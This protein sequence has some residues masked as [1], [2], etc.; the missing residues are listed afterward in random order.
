MTI[1]SARQYRQLAT[2]Y[3][4]FGF[5]L[6]PLGADK[7]P[8]VTGVAPNGRI[9]HFFWEDWK[10]T[11]QTDDLWAQIKRPEWWKDVAGLAAVCGPVSGDLV[12]IDFDVPKDTVQPFSFDV[13]GRFL[14][15]AGLAGT[16]KS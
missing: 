10:E 8:V 16:S 1:E 6:V 9:S 2:R 5:N 4:T 3:R 14:D 13:V 7:R 12:C 15:A 11:R